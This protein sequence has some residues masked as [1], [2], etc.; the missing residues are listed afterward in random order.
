M[1]GPDLLP[2]TVA[3]LER[4]GR[5]RVRGHRLYY[6]R[7]GTGRGTPVLVLHGGPGL[8]CDYLTPLADLVA[9]GYDVVLYDQLGCGGSERP[10]QYRDYTIAA[11]ADDVDE[12]RRRMGLGRVHL[13]GHS[14]GGALAVETA[15]RH[16]RALRSL[17]VS[18]GFSSMDTLWKGLRGR[19]A[20]LSP[21]S[22][23]AL[24]REDQTGRETH[25]SASGWA[26]FRRR[27]SHHLV[28]TPFEVQRTYGR[29]NGRIFRAMG[30]DARYHLRDGYRRG[31]MAGWDV[32]DRLSRIH[33][34]TLVT[35]GEFDHVVPACAR[36]IHRG[37]PGSRLVVA[38]GQGHLPFF[39]DRDGYTSLLRQFLDGTPRAR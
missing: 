28:N 1:F 18:S 7:F 37:I 14:Y 31:T 23:R 19:V 36:E 16:P 2:F 6:R 20:Q 12:L 3:E 11:N 24:I 35:V 25:A 22:R 5:V 27:F 39:E 30:F 29:M 15:L 26:E 21:K 17:V 10:V 4:E 9:G 33:V 8:T 13:F 34:P 38:R 32:S